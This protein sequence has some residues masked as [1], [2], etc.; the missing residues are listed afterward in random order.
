MTKDEFG[1]VMNSIHAHPW[2]PI[3][4]CTNLWS[5]GRDVEP[6]G[7]F[8]LRCNRCGWVTFFDRTI[9]EEKLAAIRGEKNEA[10]EPC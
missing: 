9:V 2:C 7:V 8:E 10:E 4:G 3:C 6:Y 5:F 1:L